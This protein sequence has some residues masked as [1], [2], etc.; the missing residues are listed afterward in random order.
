MISLS[1]A[2]ARMLKFKLLPGDIFILAFMLLTLVFALSSYHYLSISL[3]LMSLL[4]WLK[5]ALKQSLIY[6]AIL[7]V[8]LASYVLLYSHQI[9]YQLPNNTK[10]VELYLDEVTFN[11]EA[12]SF[13]V[14]EN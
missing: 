11:Q 3:F 2:F 4:W 14:K 9:T 12:D 1:K 6:L 8:V 13:L 10:I 7:A 5:K